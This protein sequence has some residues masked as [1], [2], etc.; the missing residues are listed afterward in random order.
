MGN[1]FNPQFKV[2]DIK[3]E[4]SAAAA[5]LI[6]SL[7]NIG[8]S[9]LRNKAAELAQLRAENAMKNDDARTALAQERLQLDNERRKADKMEA[10]QAKKDALLGLSTGTALSGNI[11]GYDPSKETEVE[12]ND[13]TKNTDVYDADTITKQLKFLD[14]SGETKIQNFKPLSKEKIKMLNEY[15]NAN[16]IENQVEKATELD[17]LNRLYFPNNKN[18]SSADAIGDY[19]S[20]VAPMATVTALG[21]VGALTHGARGIY[22]AGKELFNRF[23]ENSIDKAKRLE[24]QKKQEEKNSGFG[25]TREEEAIKAIKELKEKRRANEVARKHNSEITDKIRAVTENNKTVK[26]GTSKK[27]IRIL[28]KPSIAIPAIQ[29]IGQ[30][31][32]QKVLK[33]P[34]LPDDAKM[35][36]VEAIRQSINQRTNTYTKNYADYQQKEA[37]KNDML[38]FKAK[39][40]FKSDLKILEKKAEALLKQNSPLTE[41]QKLELQKLRQDISLKKA[42]EKKITNGF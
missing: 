28:K 30:E 6:R 15:D 41:K 25:L 23:T 11:L 5:A 21:P 9:Q 7:S 2:S 33:D 36:A 29:A 22:G 32:M 16:K 10:A 37:K 20:V 19:G 35:K 8:E 14:D 18:E 12:V 27:K 1:G 13:D 31:Q 42:Q 24:A 26:Q 17:R 4:S 39:E 38:I 3:N 40:K 34:K